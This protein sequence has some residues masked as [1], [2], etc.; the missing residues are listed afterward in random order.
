MAFRFVPSR[1]DRSIDWSRQ[2]ITTSS[3]ALPPTD[4]TS[5]QLLFMGSSTPLYH[6][7]VSLSPQGSH[8][9]P[10]SCMSA[11]HQNGSDTD[12]Y[13]PFSGRFMYP[14]T[15]YRYGN[16]GF[17]YDPFHFPNCVASQTYSHAHPLQ[18]H[19]V[20]VPLYAIP[21]PTMPMP[22][23]TSP[24]DIFPVTTFDESLSPLPSPPPLNPSHL[25]S[26]ET[27]GF[28]PIPSVPTTSPSSPI[29]NMNFD[30]V[31]NRDNPSLPF[32][33]TV[34]ARDFGCQL[35]SNNTSLVVIREAKKLSIPHF[36]LNKLSWFS[37]AMKLHA[38]LI[39]CDL[40]YLLT[41]LSTNVHNAAHSKELMLELFKKL[42]GSAISL[43]TGL[44]TQRYY[45]EGG[46]GIEMV[47]ALV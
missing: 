5:Q 20:P 47:K 2:A 15:E 31:N 21:T 34:L 30:E 37:F 45:L 11:H 6:R 23:P 25:P 24:A 44:S 16:P 41:E 13:S 1:H 43:L 46:R 35:S 40:G 17:Y 12:N 33:S 18:S 7:Q 3:H 19:P 10:S 27:P 29:L 36:D 32:N 8:Q 14:S 22:P 4:W 28:V 38:F 42:Q 9:L 26:N 39:E